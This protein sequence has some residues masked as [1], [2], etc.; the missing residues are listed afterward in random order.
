M[1]ATKGTA[2]TEAVKQITYLAGALKAPRITEA[3]S[4]LADLHPCLDPFAR[5]VWYDGQAVHV[6]PELAIPELRA[7][8]ADQFRSMLALHGVALRSIPMP[9]AR[10][11]PLWPTSGLEE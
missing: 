7:A 2:S 3:A 11:H 10:S 1:G 4:R 6:D 8:M 5:E 9:E